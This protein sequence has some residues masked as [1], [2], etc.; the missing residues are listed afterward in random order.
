MDGGAQKTLYEIRIRGLLPERW[1]RWFEGFTI[2]RLESGE[3]V[4]VGP[5]DDASALYGVIDRL[6]DL[7]LQLLQVTKLED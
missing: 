4:L 1:A 7:N 6:R 2:R 5:A 3:T